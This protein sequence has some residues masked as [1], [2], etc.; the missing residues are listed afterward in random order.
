MNKEIKWLN[1]DCS[2]VRRNGNTLAHL[3]VR[4]DTR[5]ANE[6]ICTNP[7]PQGLLTLS[8]LILC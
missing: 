3:I 6:K 7:F 5:L 1:F 4:W 2:F 8:D